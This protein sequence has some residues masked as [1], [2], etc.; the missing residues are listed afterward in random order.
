MT[1]INREA[2]LDGCLLVTIDDS[3]VFDSKLGLSGCISRM[4]VVRIGSL[5]KKLSMSGIMVLH[6]IRYHIRLTAQAYMQSDISFLARSAASCSTAGRRVEEKARS[7]NEFFY[8]GNR[9]SIARNKVELW[10][11]SSVCLN[12]AALMTAAS[13]ALDPLRFIGAH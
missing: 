3:W 13:D 7:P 11:K 4:F 6:S 5:M 10:I 2:H 9:S 1:F 12:V 8:L